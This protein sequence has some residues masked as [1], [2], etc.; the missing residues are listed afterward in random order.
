[1]IPRNIGF[2]SVSRI[3]MGTIDP[4]GELTQSFFFS[5]FFFLDNDRFF[6]IAGYLDRDRGGGEKSP[7][8]L[9]GEEGEDPVPLAR[10]KGRLSVNLRV[11]FVRVRED[12]PVCV[13]V[14]VCEKET[15][16]AI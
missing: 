8:S 2:S 6:P 7:I 11:F 4:K 13:C 15:H 5:F 1:M 12:L 14:R 10:D 9:D 3:P 16:R